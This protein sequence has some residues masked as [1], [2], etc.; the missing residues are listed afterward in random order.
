MLTDKKCK[1]MKSRNPKKSSES[2]KATTVLVDLGSGMTMHVEATVLRNYSGSKLQDVSFGPGELQ[3]QK[4]TSLLNRL[5]N[6]TLEAIKQAAPTKAGV[7]FGIDIAV[8]SGELTAL[9]VKGEAKGNLK[10]SLEWTRA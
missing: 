8:E 10:I 9:L 6:L 2:S 4:V 3:F 1:T 5:S 7:E